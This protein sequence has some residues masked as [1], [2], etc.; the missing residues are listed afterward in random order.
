MRLHAQS[1]RL[2]RLRLMTIVIAAVGIACD[3][4]TRSSADGAIG[5]NAAADSVTGERAKLAADLQTRIVFLLSTLPNNPMA[6]VSMG[7]SGDTTF[8]VN[9]G[10]DTSHIAPRIVLDDPTLI[11]QLRQVGYRAVSFQDGDRTLLLPLPAAPTSRTLAEVPSGV[12]GEVARRVFADSVAKRLREVGVDARARGAEREILF[13][14]GLSGSADV[15][16]GYANAVAGGMLG[17]ERL[18]ALRFTR[19]IVAG[20]KRSWCWNLME[21]SRP[22]ACREDEIRRLQ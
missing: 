6:S 15:A 10:N 13:V 12:A 17:I 21:T 7:A 14:D 22:V 3:S 5:R 20:P 8:S 16:L 1:N 4:D 9:I 19:M 11:A 2:L 18:R